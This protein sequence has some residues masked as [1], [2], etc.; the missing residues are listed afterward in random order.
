MRQVVPD[1]Q[2]LIASLR[3]RTEPRLALLAALYVWTDAGWPLK[4][5]GQVIL[6]KLALLALALAYPGWQSEAFMLVILL[7]AFFAH[8]PDRVRSYAWGRKVRP[9][10]TVAI[11]QENKP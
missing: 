11:I 10:K 2:T 4:L 7:S 8:A 3:N 1:A 5:K 6:A 9:C